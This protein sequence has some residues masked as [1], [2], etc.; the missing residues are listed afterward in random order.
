MCTCYI[1]LISVSAY[2]LF[3]TLEHFSLP[4]TVSLCMMELVLLLQFR[5]VFFRIYFLLYKELYKEVQNLKFSQ[6][7]Q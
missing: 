5:S 1:F 6:Q 7:C 3:V 4:S 2:G